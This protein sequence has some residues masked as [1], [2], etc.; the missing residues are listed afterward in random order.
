MSLQVC[1]CCGWSKVTTYQGLR[2]H[3]GR[4][5]CT[6]QGVRITQP[7]QQYISAFA[8]QEKVDLSYKLDQ[9]MFKTESTNYYSDMSLQ[10]CHC[11]WNKMTSYR[12][13]RIHQGRMG[14]TPKG[15]AIP[16]EEQK[17]WKDCWNPQNSPPTPRI[18]NFNNSSAAVR[19]KKQRNPTS[20]NATR[21]KSR[22]YVEEHAMFSKRPED[23]WSSVSCYNDTT[24][25]SRIK[26]EP[27]SSPDVSPQRSPD[28]H[29]VSW[30]KF[31]ISSHHLQMKRLPNKLP[32]VVFMEAVIHSEEDYR[33]VIR[34]PATPPVV[35]NDE[36]DS[37][38]PASGQEAP[39]SQLLKEIQDCLEKLRKKRDERKRNDSLSNSGHENGAKSLWIQ[40][41]SE[42]KEEKNTSPS[43][44]QSLLK[45]SDE[46][47]AAAAEQINHI[48]RKHPKA[49]PPILPKKKNLHSFAGKPEKNT[50]SSV[51]I[52]G[53]MVQSKKDS[54]E[55]EE[56]QLRAQRPP[57]VPT[58]ETRVQLKV[59]DRKEES[60]TE[61][62]SDITASKDSQKKDAPPSSETAKH[63]VST[64]N[65][66]KE[67]AQMFLGKQ[68]AVGPKIKLGQE[69]RPKQTLLHSKS[70]L[71]GKQTA[72]AT[73]IYQEHK[74]SADEA[75]QDSVIASGP[76]V[77]DL[78]RMFSTKTI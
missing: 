6:P 73:T 9:S 53:E 55:D 13:L 17:F 77:K 11:G 76:K 57:I 8:G 30:G 35:L 47:R 48:V 27:V 24:A 70:C 28:L 42:S 67:L 52:N 45:H 20:E 74:S 38:L 5:G 33:S 65:K 22:R 36:K 78:A 66:V 75:S 40:T 59:E 1:N 31:D 61:I 18:K 54:K 39:R 62:T 7:Q 26:E 56:V 25:A 50:R 34:L 14:C 69:C 41:Y 58:Q 46:S 71:T 4:M 49:R 43:A 51:I 68:T 15:A 44:R 72:K 16:K 21:S 12:G 64:G 37:P 63:V 23:C 32:A 29:N 60:A 10:I 19:V 3:Q 2:I